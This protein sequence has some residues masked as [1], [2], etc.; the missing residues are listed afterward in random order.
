MQ[1]QLPVLTPQVYVGD[2]RLCDADTDLGMDYALSRLAA[3]WRE[4]PRTPRPRPASR[5]ASRARPPP[6]QRA[7]RQPGE[8]AGR[9]GGGAAPSAG[10]SGPRGRS[11]AARRGARAGRRAAARAGGRAPAPIAEPEQPS[12]EEAP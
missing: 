10:A 1:N 12:P 2:L 4:S 7:G 6:P 8:R 5:R 3:R 11:G 9:A